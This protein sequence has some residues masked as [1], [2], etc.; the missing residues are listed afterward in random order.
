MRYMENVPELLLFL[1]VWNMCFFWKWWKNPF[2]LSTSEVLSSY[3]PI[4]CYMKGRVLFKD[5]VYLEYPS[6]MGMYSPFYF[7]QNL[8]GFLCQKLPMDLKF[9]VFCYNILVHYYLA[10]VIAFFMLLQWFSPMVSIFGALTLVYNAHNIRLQTPCFVFSSCW[11]MGVLI[12]GWVGAF[13]FGMALLGGY[14]PILIT[15][16]PILLFNPLSL[17]GTVIA[18][19]QLISILWYYPKSIRAVSAPDPAWG[20]MPWKRY[21]MSLRFPENSVHYP[22]YSF[23]IGLCFFLAFFN[24]SWWWI[25]VIFGLIGAH[26]AFNFARVPARFVYLVTISLVMTS[27]GA[28]GA[29]RMHYLVLPLLLTQLFLLWPNRAQYPSF[30]FSQ[31]WRK[32]SFWFTKYVKSAEWPYFTGYMWG[33]RHSTYRGGFRLKEYN[34]E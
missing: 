34:A 30:P 1:A 24:W 14:F 19:P 22:E 25:L 13:C 23:N 2:L 6:A 12:K 33:K 29:P 20:R 18:L 26:G 10:S 17:L 4:W 21:F 11:M 7:L 15:A 16:L 9:I 8:L 28:L 3:F 31:W 32:P 5:D 27:L